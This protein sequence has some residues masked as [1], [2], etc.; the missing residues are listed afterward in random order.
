MNLFDEFKND[1]AGLQ[2]LSDWL[3]EGG[4]P[5][6]PTTSAVRALACTSGNEG[7][8]CPHNRSPNFLE[9]AK[10]EIA[11]QI[12]KQ[13]EIKHRLKI[14]TPLDHSLFMCDVCGCHL[15]LKVQTPL[16]HLAAHTEE[17]KL[18]QFPGYCWLRIE[19]ENY[20]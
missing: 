17:K 10:G 11:D 18:S 16:K 19:V 7:R 14:S 2:T 3:G 1:V 15:P 5:V 12:R 20:V 9:S 6:E 4:I 13:L 8:A